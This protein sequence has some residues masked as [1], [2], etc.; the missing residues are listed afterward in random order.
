MNWNITINNQKIMYLRIKCDCRYVR[1]CEL[2][3][4]EIKM[5]FHLNSMFR[6]N[7]I[8]MIVAS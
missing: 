4:D 7:D 6:I 1:V 3:C 2:S 5:V 8:A